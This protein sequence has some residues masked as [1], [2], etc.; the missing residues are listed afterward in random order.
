VLANVRSS[1][2]LHLPDEEVGAILGR[3]GQ[4]LVDIQQSARVTIKIS[5][6]SKMDPNTSEREV[7]ISGVHSAVKLAEAMVAER[8]HQSRARALNSG[9]RSTEGGAERG[10]DHAA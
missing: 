6:R 10:E 7:T 1:L 2:T 8:L 4:T 9:P 3:R 5:D